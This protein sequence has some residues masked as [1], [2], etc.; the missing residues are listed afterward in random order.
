M[1]L[2]RWWW[3]H[4]RLRC[5]YSSDDV[6]CIRNV[7]HSNL[8]YVTDYCN[9]RFSC[10]SSV[11]QGEFQSRNLHKGYGHF[12]LHPFQFTIT[13]ILPFEALY[14]T[15]SRKRCPRSNKRNVFLFLWD[16]SL[17]FRLQLAQLP[18]PYSDCVL[19]YGWNP[20]GLLGIKKCDYTLSS[21]WW[22]L[23]EVVAPLEG[24]IQR[25]VSRWQP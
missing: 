18:D 10:L 22:S 20:R 5:P 21:F 2:K 11:S 6:L 14:S 9:L 1:S 16:Y 4:H 25:D 13:I 15:Q 23:L 3:Y 17:W 12:L 24:L 8:G 7:R 19:S